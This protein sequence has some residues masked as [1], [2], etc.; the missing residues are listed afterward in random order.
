MKT[1]VFFP[2]GVWF[3]SST[4]KM[5]SSLFA[6]TVTASGTYKIRKGGIMFFRGN[7]EPWFFLVA[8]THGERFFVS[9]SKQPDGKT[10]YS[11]ALSSLEE[12][13]LGMPKTL[14][15]CHE[16]AESIFDSLTREPVTA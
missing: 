9:C 1:N 8:N 5:V 7:G 6:T 12:K 14:R 4:G 13:A 15:E 10:R 3:T 2:N 16:L 11:F